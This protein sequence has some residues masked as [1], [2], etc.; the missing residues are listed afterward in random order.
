[1]GD[2]NIY[3]GHYFDVPAITE[4][5]TKAQRMLA[6]K[7]TEFGE[8]LKL[9]YRHYLKRRRFPKP[10]FTFEDGLLN[11]VNSQIHRSA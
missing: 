1:M 5:I 11:W 4:I 9:T 2:R 8:G 6:F 7:P 3:F 10:D